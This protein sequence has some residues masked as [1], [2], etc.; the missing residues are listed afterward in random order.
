M[1]TPLKPFIVTFQDTLRV[2]VAVNAR[3][4]KDA[5]RKAIKQW[6]DALWDKADP[7]LAG[8]DSEIIES[9]NRDFFEV[10]V[11]PFADLPTNERKP[12]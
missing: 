1:S 7:A 12:K 9:Y 2:R 3:Y 5:E 4:P 11:D 10:E 8:T 6:S